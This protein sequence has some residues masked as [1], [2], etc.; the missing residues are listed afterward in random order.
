MKRVW[1]TFK[2]Y[3]NGVL[4]CD[5]KRSEKILTYAQHYFLKPYERMSDWGLNGG[6]DHPNMLQIAKGSNLPCYKL[7]LGLKLPCYKLPYC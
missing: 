1:I 6:E 3:K 5:G 7:P 4:N 2:Y